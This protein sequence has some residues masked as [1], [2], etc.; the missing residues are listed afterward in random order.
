MRT[1]GDSDFAFTLNDLL[2]TSLSSIS[3]HT[4]TKY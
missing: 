1:I 3:G 2:L 4:G